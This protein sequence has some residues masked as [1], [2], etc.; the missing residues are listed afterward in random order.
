MFIICSTL[1]STRSFAF[2]SLNANLISPDD[3]HRHEE[4]TFEDYV[5][6]VV[7]LGVP[8]R[9]H[10]FSLS[11]LVTPLHRRVKRQFDNVAIREAALQ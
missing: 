8:R 1:S 5:R 3:N 11:S 7:Q 2:V 6:V 4:V 10:F 9:R